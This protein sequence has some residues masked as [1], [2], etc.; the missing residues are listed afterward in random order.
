MRQIKFDASKQELPI[1][2]ASSKK[3]NTGGFCQFKKQ[4]IG[5]YQFSFIFIQVSFSFLYQTQNMKSRN[6]TDNKI[7]NLKICHQ[8]RSIQTNL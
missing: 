4:L 6:I 1:V 5:Y 8:L 7:C 2:F 3:I